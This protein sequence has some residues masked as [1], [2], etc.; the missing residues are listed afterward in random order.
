MVN[1][2][3]GI[4]NGYLFRSHWLYP[5][6]LAMSRL[7]PLRRNFQLTNATSR[8]WILVHAGSD[9]SALNVDNTHSLRFPDLKHVNYVKVVQRPYF[10]RNKKTMNGIT[11]NIF[12]REKGHVHIYSPV[13][14][15]KHPYH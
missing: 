11:L 10:R 5:N 9:I 3:T 7:G 15:P 4:I 8:A 2:E 6:S 1:S 12:A 14:P 13:L